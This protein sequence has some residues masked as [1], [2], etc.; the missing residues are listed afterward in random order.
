MGKRK[1]SLGNPPIAGHF[2]NLNPY[3]PGEPPG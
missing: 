1:S 3:E 2:G